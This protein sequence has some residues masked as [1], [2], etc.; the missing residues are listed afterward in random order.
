[1]SLARGADFAALA[2]L[3]QTVWVALACPVDGVEFD[4]ETLALLDADGDGRIRAVELLGAIDWALQRLKDPSELLAADAA[5]P[6][7]A[8]DTEHPGGASI[9]AAAER[10]LQETGRPGE[11]SISLEA[12]SAAAGIL[13]TRALN[14]DGVVTPASTE[15]AG[16][17]STLEAAIA[18]GFGLPDRSGGAGIDAAGAEAF[19]A[20]VTA[21]LAWRGE[22]A[23]DSA[24][25]PLGSASAAAL[26]ATDAIAAR[27]DD[28][29]ARCALARFDPRAEAALN[30]E[31]Q[32]WLALAA[33]DLS[34]ETEEIRAFPLARV[35]A[36]AELP[37]VEGLNPAWSAELARFVADAL[38]PLLG[39]RDTLA[40]ADWQ[41]LKDLLAPCRDWLARKPAAALEALSDEALAEHGSEARRS[42]LLELIAAD[43]ALA[44]AYDALADL[45]KLVRLRRDLAAFCRN[46]VNFQ[47]FYGARHPASFQCGTLYI[48]QRS[49]RL[50]LKVADSA[51]HAAI[52]GLAGACLV[53]CECRR[54]GS[55]ET[56]QI[57][58]AVTAGDSDNLMVGRNGI[59]YDRSGRDWDATVT[60]IVDS[61]VS[62]RQAFWS[63]YRKLARFIEEQV[64]KRAA[65]ADAAGNDKLQTVVLQAPG[66]LT[67][68]PAADA[69]PAVPARRVDVGTVAALGVALGSLGTAFGY[70]LRT[71]AE[72][73]AWQIPL[74]LLGIMLAISGP[75]MI[76]AWLKLRRRNVAPLLDAS[77][78]AVNAR[79][80]VNL[81]FGATLTTLAALPADARLGGDSF[82]A[83]GSAGRLLVAA[84]LIWWALA[85]AGD[86][87]WLKGLGVMLP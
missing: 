48:D 6:V 42:A 21:A 81:P 33:R 11:A 32:A 2:S 10:V 73:R 77:G 75:S 68:P 87:G 45:V 25:L 34:I 26:A 64:A 52:A 24:V 83:H 85:F 70:F 31:E 9:A 84:F 12:A 50:C 78:W 36:R 46:F 63:P 80:L 72:I 59:F 38:E 1:V 14:G 82:E 29:F 16:L 40:E 76:L 69:K 62:V 39:P 43:A 54:A 19:F 74:L 17:R 13:A 15:D 35:Y 28:Y 4:P 27:I 61:P 49:C 7:A 8:L 56:M 41:A 5:L 37:L 18:A 3:D 51:K 53:Y 66:K 30:R 71:L 58:A 60:R 22:G 86:M 47:D 57:V 67:E 20:A 23:S 79:A 55:G 44:P 65:A